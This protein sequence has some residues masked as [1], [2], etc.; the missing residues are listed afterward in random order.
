M[1]RMQYFLA[2]CDGICADFALL[3]NFSMLLWVGGEQKYTV[4]VKSKHDLHQAMHEMHAT[5]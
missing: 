3:V 4:D 5:T 2:L 1:D